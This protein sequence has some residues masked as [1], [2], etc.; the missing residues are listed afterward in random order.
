MKVFGSNLLTAMKCSLLGSYNVLYFSYI[1]VLMMLSFV[2]FKLSITN[3]E[4]TFIYNIEYFANKTPFHIKI[5][6]DMTI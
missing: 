5:V 6:T 4:Y 3:L 1:S 2:N